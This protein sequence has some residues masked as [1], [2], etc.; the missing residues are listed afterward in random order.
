MLVISA[1]IAFG[2]VAFWLYWFIS[3]IG[4]KKN[5]IPRIQRFVGLRILLFLLV[6]LLVRTS[7][8]QANLSKVQSLA[9]TNGWFLGIGF[10]LFLL[11][12]SLAIWA[13]LY[14]GKNWGMPMSLKQDPELVTSGPYRFIRHPIYTGILL[15]TFGTAL[16][17]NI[18]FLFLLLIMGVYFI[19][20]ATVEEKNMQAQFP[21][22]YPSYKN[23]TKM[24]IPFVF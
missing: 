22:V 23:K 4:A 19:Y 8:A 13:R 20:S 2:W 18:Y 24:L 5:A 10:T 11:G 15:A 1:L 12:L 6:I 3:A 16:A 17:S 21:K 14:I 9:I 7:V